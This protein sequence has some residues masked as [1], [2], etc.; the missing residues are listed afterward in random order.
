MQGL[1]NFNLLH[2]QCKSTIQDLSAQKR[3]QNQFFL[4]AVSCFQELLFLN[5]RS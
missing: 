4:S 1:L 2:P 3:S 5:H